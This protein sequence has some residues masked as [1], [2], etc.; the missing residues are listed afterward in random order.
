MLPVCV[1]DCKNRV[2][3]VVGVLGGGEEMSVVAGILPDCSARLTPLMIDLCPANQFQSIHTRD[4]SID[5]R[6][7]A[8]DHPNLVPSPAV[9]LRF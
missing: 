9:V 4:P 3:R 7:I 2:E 5:E 8:S 1:A 6:T